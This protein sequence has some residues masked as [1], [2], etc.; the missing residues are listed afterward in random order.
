[1]TTSFAKNMYQADLVKYYD[2]MHQH[3]NYCQE[4]NFVNQLIHRYCP[5]TTQVLDIGCGTGEHAVRMAQRGYTVTAIDTSQD[6]IALAQ[7][8]AQK[9]GVT[10]DFQCT[11]IQSLS[12]T[13]GFQAIYALGY[14]FLYMTTYA[15]IMSFLTASYQALQHQGVFLVDFI[16]GWSLIDQYPRDKF[17]YHRGNTTIFCFH[18]ASLK[19]PERVK[20]IEFYY[21]ISDHDGQVKTIFTEEDLRIFFDDEVQ[22][23]FTH[24]GFEQ[25]TSFRDY[26]FET[27]QSGH[28]GSIILVVG[29]KY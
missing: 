28:D 7:E 6:M 15:D 19:K 14:T 1:M 11:D 29:Q 3:R 16:N 23:F 5:G 25:V 12:L 9:A 17:V 8:K 13:E 27:P 10:I 2:V 20:H 21:V 26:S 18:Q 4:C 24:C 22:L